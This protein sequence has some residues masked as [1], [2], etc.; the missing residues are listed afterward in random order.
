MNIKAKR[1]H[2]FNF[3]P[4]SKKQLMVLNWW[5]DNSPVKD[6]KMM[7]ADGSIR[8]GKTLAIT[9]SFILF[10]MRNYSGENAAIAGKSVGAVRRNIIPNMLSMLLSLG[11]EYVEHRSDNYIEIIKGDVVNNIYLFGLK[12]ATSASH[13]Q[14]LTLAAAF[15]DECVIADRD[16]FNQLIG[17]CSVDG[18]KIF[19]SCNPESPYHWFYTDFIRQAKKKNILYIHFNMDDNPSLSDEIKEDYRRMFSGVWA[20]RFILGKWVTANGLVYDMWNDDTHIIDFN[21]IPFIDAQKWCLSIDYG[22][23]NATCGL[24]CF[25]SYDGD[26]Y[27]VDEYFHAGGRLKGMEDG[28]D[29]FDN[30]EGYEAQKTDLEYAND[31]KVF[32]MDNQPFTSLAWRQIDLVVDPAA[33]SFCLQLRKSGMRVKHAN[34]SV[35]DGIRTVA[36]YLGN[37]KLFISNKCKNLIDEMHTYSWDEKAQ[38]KGL[39]VPVKQNDHAADSLRYG[40]MF[41]KDKR[42]SSRAAINVGYW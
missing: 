13:I 24:L 1:V 2:K 29:N 38:V 32:M 27:V 7:I 19:C 14:G 42:D 15:I 18:S 10:V 33:A 41:L 37:N 40:I 11:Y 21:D 8:A 31:M 9:L 26:I 23:A 30:V 6:R 35:L 3:K 4:F 12:D 22:T 39:D 25:K 16:G 20:D 17:R 28:E 34:N 5:A 36:T